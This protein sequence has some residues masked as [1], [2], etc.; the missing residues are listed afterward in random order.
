LRAVLV[1]QVVLVDVGRPDG[2]PVAKDELG[3]HSL[4]PWVQTVRAA[5]LLM[6]QPGVTD[7]DHQRLTRQQQ[8]RAA[9]EGYT[10][11]DV[12]IVRLRAARAGEA[13]GEEDGGRAYTVR[14]M[15]RGH[16]RQQPYGPQRALRRPVWINPHVKGPADAPLTHTERVVLVDRDH[17][18]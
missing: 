10:T 6:T 4:S 16:W 7:V 18:D 14:W 5:W 9:R 11:T 1:G 8:R 13:V 17:R 3:E 2:T 15:V 12:K